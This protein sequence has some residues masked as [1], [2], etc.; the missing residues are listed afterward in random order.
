MTTSDRYAKL[1]S[2]RKWPLIATELINW[3]KQQWGIE[4]TSLR[5]DPESEIERLGLGV[6]YEVATTDNV[7]GRLDVHTQE[8][9]VYDTMNARH[10][11]FTLL[12]EVGHY[13]QKNHLGLTNA[14][15]TLDRYWQTEAPE[16][17][18]DSFA[19]SVL[20]PDEELPSL[21][22]PPTAADILRLYDR[23]NASYL[24]CAMSTIRGNARVPFVIVGIDYNAVVKFAVASDDSLVPPS[25]NSVQ[26]SFLRALASSHNS[27]CSRTFET[28]SI[29]YES[30]RT[31]D[32]LKATVASSDEGLVIAVISQTPGH[33]RPASWSQAQA[34]CA[35]PACASV[36]DVTPPIASCPEC[37]M[38][39]C[40]EC[41]T[42]YC[43]SVAI[44]KTCPRCFL[45][46]S[47]SELEDPSSHEC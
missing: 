32:D 1:L 18:A 24:A 5:D 46:Y 12:H 10:D 19:A 17:I 23:T 14:I 35:N 15:A 3:Q 28:V 31:R 42:C 11:M 38:P 33:F 40:P 6:R 26:P 20:I 9:V 7:H 43:N 45:A 30:G 8:I 37:G 39:I 47:V 2:E 13:V 44:S 27:E 16:K 29:Q 22:T 21:S 25:R 41:R 36:F 4:A 34:E